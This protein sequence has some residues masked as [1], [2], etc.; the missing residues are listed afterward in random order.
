MQG[1][2][3]SCPTCKK[4]V[5]GLFLNTGWHC[6]VC[7]SEVKPYSNTREYTQ[8]LPY[9]LVPDDIKGAMG[10][11]PTSIKV[12]PAFSSLQRV[13]PNSYAF[14]TESGTLYCTC[15]GL[16][17]KRYDT[18]KKQMTPYIG[19]YGDSCG[20]YNEGRCKMSGVFSFYLPEVDM[21]CGYRIKT[22]SS[23]SISN[24]ISTLMKISDDQGKISRVVCELRI[25]EKKR[26]SDGKRY[27][28]LELIPPAFSLQKVLELKG[29]GVSDDLI[30]MSAGLIP[31]TAKG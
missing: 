30:A 25:I 18:A 1:K 8:S 26:T 20:S 6:A 16:A 31:R 23:Q 10:D 13:I 29:Q 21:F 11:K 19:P 12:I 5:I 28:V 4:E 22:K 2:E 24:I 7:N 15:D 27:R 9:F 3:S 17:G 14:Y